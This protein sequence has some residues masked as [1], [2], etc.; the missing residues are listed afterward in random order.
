[1]NLTIDKV[2]IDRS[3]IKDVH[4]MRSAAIVQSIVALSRSLGMRVTAEG[5]E[6]QEQHKILRASGCHFLQGFLFSRPVC[7]EDIT[8]LIADSRGMAILPASANAADQLP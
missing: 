6:T 5:V 2:K 4:L 7:A 8:A 1:M 3:F